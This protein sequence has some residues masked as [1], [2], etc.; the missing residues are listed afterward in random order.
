[1]IPVAHPHV[2]HGF[3]TVI[4]AILQLL[5]KAIRTRHPDFCVAKL[6]PCGRCNAAAKLHG[7][8]LHP[9]ADAEHRHPERINRRRGARR[10]GVGD[11]LRAAGKDD[12]TRC[13]V[14][15]LLVRD[16]PGMNFAVHTALAHPAGDE[17]RVLRAEVE[18][19]YPV[20]MNVGNAGHDTR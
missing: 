17:L 5:E 19:Q 13:K 1:M 18:Y 2:E 14:A 8:R 10:I 12:A 11:R 9:V 16:V 6:A 7:H 15:H 3:A 20:C 4:A